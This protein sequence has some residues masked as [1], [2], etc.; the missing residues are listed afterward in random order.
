MNVLQMSVSAGILILI[1][2]GI[3]LFAMNRLPKTMF[4]TL[5]GI[6][7]CRLI[8]PYSIPSKLS[9]YNAIN[10]FSEEFARKAGVAN[11]DNTRVLIYRSTGNMDVVYKSLQIEPIMILWIAG[12][13]FLALFFAASFYKSY[14]EIRTALPIKGNTL[15]DKWL[16][17]QKT[18]RSIRIL[19][20]DRITTP[21]TYGIIKPKIILPKS[22]DYKNEMQMRYILAHELIH[23]KRFDALWKLLL[24]MVLCF[25]WFNPMVWVLYILMNRDLEIACDEKVIKLFGEDTKSEYALSLIEMAER[26]TNFTPLYSSF[27]KNATEERIV[28]IMKFKKTSVFSLVLAFML[29]AGATFV[30]AESTANKVL[31]LYGVIQTDSGRFSFDL[32]EK[33]VVTVKNADGKV[34]STTTVDS[35]GKATL[36]DGSG[37]TIKTLQLDIPKQPQGKRVII[38][39]TA[40]LS[41]KGEL[42]VKNE[43]SAGIDTLPKYIVEVV[44]KTMVTVKDTDGNVIGTGTADNNGMAIM[45]DNSGLKIGN[46]TVKDGTVTKLTVNFHNNGN[47]NAVFF[48]TIE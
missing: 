45:T 1:I 46:A 31:R 28:S 16:S 30:F 12:T 7:L 47:S 2:A 25:H 34:I 13:A 48:G 40:M 27:S 8:I 20:S 29:V 33:G 3:R 26:R 18:N 41:E 32:D 35:D 21:L 4:I 39:K 36:T 43:G 22:M 19:V 9:I 24:V 38:Y 6:A 15:I 10:R 5:W 42:D 11:V 23:I 37:K 14:R 44:G 17:E